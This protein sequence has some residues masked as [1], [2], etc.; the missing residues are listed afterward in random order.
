MRAIDGGTTRSPRR[1]GRSPAPSSHPLGAASLKGRRRAAP[2]RPVPLERIARPQGAPP[3]APAPSLPSLAAGPTPRPSP[4]VP[5][6]LPTR[7]P[8]LPRRRSEPRPDEDRVR[9]RGQSSSGRAASSLWTG[10]ATVSASLVGRSPPRRSPACR[11]RL[12]EIVG[13]CRPAEGD[14]RRRVRAAAGPRVEA[15]G[16]AKPGRCQDRAVARGCAGGGG[17]R[18]YGRRSRA[19]RR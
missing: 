14:C 16:G 5:P 12:S 7:R 10:R 19:E 6:L 17:L 2:P 15:R 8:R 18:L 13:D 3:P 9:G 4:P 1:S 11:G